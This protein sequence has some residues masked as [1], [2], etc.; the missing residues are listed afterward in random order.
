MDDV[1]DPCAECGGRCCSFKTLRI[2]FRGLD[3]GQRYDS[4]FTDEDT[5]NN[6]LLDDGTVPDMDFY[7]LTYPDGTRSLVFDCNHLTDD[8]LCGVYDNR[9]ELC[10][11]FVCDALDPDDDTTL[12]EFLESTTWNDGERDQVELTDVTDRIHDQIRR[13]GTL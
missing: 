2:S 3:K 4:V 13:H 12:D 8:G 5:A 6:V 11:S 10:R 9:P 1:D 7:V